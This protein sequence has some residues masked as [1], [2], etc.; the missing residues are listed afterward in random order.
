MASDES[1]TYHGARQVLRRTLAEL[2]TAAGSPSLRDISKG[3]SRG[4]AQRE[5]PEAPSHETIRK[6]I[7]VIGKPRWQAVE[8]VVRFLAASCVAPRDP[9]ATVQHIF[10]L[11]R[12]VIEQAN[13]SQSQTVAIA[14]AGLTEPSAEP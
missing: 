10:R 12:L 6:V 4:Y 11:W 3:L 13:D 8:A 7:K 1:E 5:Y 2:C 14:Q 9:D